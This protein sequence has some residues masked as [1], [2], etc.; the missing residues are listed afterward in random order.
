MLLSPS[1]SPAPGADRWVETLGPGRRAS[2]SASC[3]CA[4]YRCPSTLSSS[5]SALT[6]DW[7]SARPSSGLKADGTAA[8]MRYVCRAGKRAVSSDSS[9]ERKVSRSLLSFP[10]ALSSI[11]AGYI[12]G[13][14][15]RRRD[16][17]CR[18]AVWTGDAAAATLRDGS[19]GTGEG[20]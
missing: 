10:L 2:L 9:A 7:R 18:T 17:R 3:P 11:D 13:T 5:T 6:P 14:S 19:S 8:T 16:S 12:A 15:G 4:R 20:E 1:P